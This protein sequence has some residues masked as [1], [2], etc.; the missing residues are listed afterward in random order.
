MNKTMHGLLKKCC[1]N[2]A[3]YMRGEMGTD[4]YGVDCSCGC[5]YFLDFSGDWGVCA[6]PDSIRAGL[7]TWEHQG[8]AD[9]FKGSKFT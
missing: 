7:L 6:N 8:C 3:E 5:K 2:W 4:V 1:R 9:G